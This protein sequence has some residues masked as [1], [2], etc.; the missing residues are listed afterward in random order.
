[1]PE[2]RMRGWSADDA[3][4]RG[5]VTVSTPKLQLTRRGVP[6]RAAVPQFGVRKA[7]TKKGRNFASSAPL[8]GQRDRRAALKPAATQAAFQEQV[9]DDSA[10]SS[11][12]LYGPMNA[13]RNAGGNSW[14][15]KGGS[16]GGSKGKG[17]GRGSK[18]SGKGGGRGGNGGAGR[19]G[20]GRGKGKW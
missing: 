13:R 18:S 7:I 14:R 10:Y 17:K 5:R 19:K 9:A 12:G 3:P 20:K 2:D 16:K 1:M 6:Q 15:P 4:A 11:T 8:V